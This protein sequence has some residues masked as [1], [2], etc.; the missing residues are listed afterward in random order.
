M[1]APSLDDAGPPHPASRPRPNNLTR[2][3]SVGFPT[4]VCLS[5]NEN[6]ARIPIGAGSREP[7]HLLGGQGGEG[8]TSA[9]SW[10]REK[11]LTEPAQTAH[12]I[13]SWKCRITETALGETGR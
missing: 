11:F 7:S 6:P 3:P 9:N 13:R 5:P 8:S 10:A 4:K 12:T 2:G 1:G